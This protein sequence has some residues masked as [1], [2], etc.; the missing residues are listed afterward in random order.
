MEKSDIKAIISDY[1][2]LEDDLNKS[3]VAKYFKNFV[4]L[5]KYHR[6][7]WSNDCRV[8]SQENVG[9]N[10]YDM[11]D[12]VINNYEN[13]PEKML[14]ARGCLLFPQGRKK[15]LSNGNCSSGVLEYKLSKTCNI[16]QVHNYG[17]D[18]TD[19]IFNYVDDGIYAEKVSSWWFISH[20]G[21]YYYSHK[22]F[23][24]DLYLKKN[25]IKYT[26]FSP[27]ASYI[28]HRDVIL[29]YP[30]NLYLNLRYLVA[31]DCVVGEAHL[32]ERNLYEIFT[33]REEFSNLYLGDHDT[34]RK[35]MNKR[36]YVTNFWNNTIYPLRKL[37]KR[38]FFS[39]IKKRLN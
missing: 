16:I 15:P 12:Y 36:I 14:F 19:G 30:K 6:P 9:Q 37:I 8:I 5:D 3:W 33:A 32:L 26:R 24:N 34:F 39:W 22:K 17:K 11:L 4:I 25:R 7:H 28:I 2:W 23:L 27:G 10:I 31:W 38:W 21:R 20:P 13:L 1:N 35:V 29:K 18:L